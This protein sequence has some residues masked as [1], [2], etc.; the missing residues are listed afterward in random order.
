MVKE[1]MARNIVL[2]REGKLGID[3]GGGGVYGRI[4]V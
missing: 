4:E 2:A 3:V 1:D